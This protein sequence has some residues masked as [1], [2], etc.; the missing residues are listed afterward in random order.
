MSV[1]IGSP[2]EMLTMD[3]LGRLPVSNNGNKYLLVV[4]DYYKVARGFS[5]A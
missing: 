4:S 1:P 3:I 2:M 5:V